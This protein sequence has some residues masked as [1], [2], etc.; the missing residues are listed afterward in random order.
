VIRGAEIQTA[1]PPQNKANP[2]S[3]ANASNADSGAIAST[4]GGSVAA[5]VTDSLPDRDLSRLVER[6]PSLS[7]ELREAVLRVAGVST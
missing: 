2:A 1:E 5:F 4:E 3:N 6:W 7:P